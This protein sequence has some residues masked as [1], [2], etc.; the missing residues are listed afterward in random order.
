[1]FPG[2]PCKVSGQNFTFQGNGCR[3]DSR[4]GQLRLPHV[5]RPKYENLKELTTPKA[6][7]DKPIVF[8]FVVF[9]LNGA[10]GT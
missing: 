10:T 7:V 6:S 1:M 5:S 9:G 8:W 3:F 4:V 2:L